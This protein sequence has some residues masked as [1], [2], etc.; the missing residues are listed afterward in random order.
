MRRR[1]EA[2]RR[3]LLLA[4]VTLLLNLPNYSLQ[5]IDEFYHFRESSDLSIRRKFVRVSTLSSWVC[6]EG[7]KQL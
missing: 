3:C 7:V 5:L 2:I 1:N 6:L 4:T